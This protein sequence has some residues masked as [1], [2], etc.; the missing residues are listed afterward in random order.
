MLDTGLRA[1]S[2]RRVYEDGGDWKL[3]A[4]AG[5]AAISAN[6]KAGGIAED[7]TREI[8]RSF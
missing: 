7:V 1:N 4:A 8:Y 3:E 5:T 6:I 2:V